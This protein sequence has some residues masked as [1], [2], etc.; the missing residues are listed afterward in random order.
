MFSELDIGDFISQDKLNQ[1]LKKLYYTD[2]FKEVEISFENKVVIINVQENPIIQDITI[3]G[4]DKNSLY[5]KIKEITSRIEKYR[6]NNHA[7]KT[8]LYLLLG[9]SCYI[10]LL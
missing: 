6:S 1:A 2:Y 8:F 7:R 5:D 3:D 4:V 10:G 9:L